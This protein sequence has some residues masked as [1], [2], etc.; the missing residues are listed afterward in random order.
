[1]SSIVQLSLSDIEGFLWQAG[2]VRG[3]GV[4]VR[5]RAHPSFSRTF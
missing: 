1:M 3:S 5:V 4:L 2:Q